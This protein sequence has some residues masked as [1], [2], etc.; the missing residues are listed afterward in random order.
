MDY[1]LEILNLKKR[2]EELENI[3][4]NKPVEKNTQSS[5]NRDKTKYMFEG[6]IYAKNENTKAATS[7][8]AEIIKAFEWASMP[9]LKFILPPRK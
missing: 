1:E 6:K 7:T 9:F 2:I 8:T 3:I 4:L 5:S